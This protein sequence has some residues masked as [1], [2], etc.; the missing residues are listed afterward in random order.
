MRVLDS[1]T[2][3]SLLEQ[4]NTLDTIIVEG[5]SDKKSLLSFDVTIPIIVLKRMSL[6]KIVESL[7]R[8]SRIAVLTD[9]DSEGKKLYSQLN[10]ECSQRGIH[11]DNSLREFLFKNTT[12]RQIEGMKR[13]VERRSA[14]GALS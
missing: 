1:E 13:Y 7:P 8:G 11:I 3:F 12:L 4:L 2:M 9:L 14:T 10:H 6:F 5:T